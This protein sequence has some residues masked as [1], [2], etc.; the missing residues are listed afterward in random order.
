MDRS[1]RDEVQEVNNEDAEEIIR[2]AS[3]FSGVP[4]RQMTLQ[5]AKRILKRQKGR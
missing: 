5:R 3:I 2:L 4:K 1:P